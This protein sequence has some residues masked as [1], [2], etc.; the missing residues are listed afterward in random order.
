LLKQSARISADWRLSRPFPRRRTPQS[1][2][3]RTT[4]PGSAW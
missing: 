2:A 4:G 3:A 1:S